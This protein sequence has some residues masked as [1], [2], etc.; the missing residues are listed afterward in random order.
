ME[1][2]LFS[3]ADHHRL[4]VFEGV[5]LLER[6]VFDCLHQ[7]DMGKLIPGIRSYDL[8]RLVGQK[9]CMTC[10]QRSK[11]LTAIFV[12]ELLS[13]RTVTNELGTRRVRV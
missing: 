1:V 3:D 12:G 13:F 8:R 9:L 11:Y 4:L 2:R 7:T 10:S 5:A 6:I